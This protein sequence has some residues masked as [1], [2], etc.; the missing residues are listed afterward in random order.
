[1]LLS[2]WRIPSRQ[3]VSSSV[4]IRGGDEGEMWGEK[5]GEAEGKKCVYV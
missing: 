3:W 1:V 4:V 5:K 2:V